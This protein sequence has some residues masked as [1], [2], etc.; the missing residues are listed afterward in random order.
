VAVVEILEN[1]AMTDTSPPH[2]AYQLTLKIGAD[3]ERA[4][5]SALYNLS[6]QVAAGKISQHCVSGGYDS[7]YIWDLKHDPEMTGDRYRTMPSLIRAIVY[8][9]DCMYPIRIKGWE[10]R[11]MRRWR[12]R[13]DHREAT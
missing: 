1:K 3:D 4:L 13:Q 2:R 10:K 7:G 9:W 5:A 12:R 6:N 8:G 11:A